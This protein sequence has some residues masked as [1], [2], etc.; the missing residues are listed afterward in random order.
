VTGQWP[1]A[2]PQA[3]TATTITSEAPAKASAASIV[4]SIY[5]FGPP[6]TFALTELELARH[7]R[8][9]RRAGWLEWEIRARFG[10]CAA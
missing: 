3:A 6:S 9:L 2:R 1:P 10:R 8:D 5:A 7:V 4:T